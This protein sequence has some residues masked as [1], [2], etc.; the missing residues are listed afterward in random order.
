MKSIP[1][2]SSKQTIHSV[3]LTLIL[4]LGVLSARAADENLSLSETVNWINATLT[5]TN[6]SIFKQDSEFDP[7]CQQVWFDHYSI[8]ISTDGALQLEW[9]HYCP[10]H[11]YGEE[12][13]R[14]GGTI[15]FWKTL[16]ADAVQIVHFGQT[17]DATGGGK[18]NPNLPEVGAN[19]SVIAVRDSDGR[20]WCV[21]PNASDHMLD[22]FRH[23]LDKTKEERGNPFK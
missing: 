3:V 18:L 15:D 10:G 9:E 20:Y 17:V 8:S 21:V 12:I 13:R 22:A 7:R 19:T 2:F 6:K 23:L 1:T 14:D 11:K 5:E 16:K 4:A